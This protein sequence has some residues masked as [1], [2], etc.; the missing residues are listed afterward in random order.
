[1]KTGK[2]YTVKRN[3]KIFIDMGVTHGCKVLVKGGIWQ[4]KR[5]VFMNYSLNESG[6]TFRIGKELL[7]DVD[8]DILQLSDDDQI[9]DV[10]KIIRNKDI[11]LIGAPIYWYT[12]GGILKTF[13][14]RIYL[15]K[16]VLRGKE[17]Y[18]FAQ[19]SSLDENTVNMIKYL[20][21]RVSQIMS[22]KLKSVI[23]DSSQSHKIISDM[24]IYL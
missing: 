6:K 19:G 11:I 4:M 18:L 14:D 10:L 15:L 17:L 13:V 20:A 7:K 1:M 16:E 9:S 5:T 12:V 22:M 23:V 24:K 2:V 8:H 3:K 21:K